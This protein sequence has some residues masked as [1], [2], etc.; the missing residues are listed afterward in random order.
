MM[1]TLIAIVAGAITVAVI[2]FL[3]LIAQ[4]IKYD[5]RRDPL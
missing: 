5:D 1:C 2:G 4:S 3:W